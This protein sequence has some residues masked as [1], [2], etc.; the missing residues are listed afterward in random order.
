MAERK[1]A[2]SAR[3]AA[4][5]GYLS[6]LAAIDVRSLLWNL[7]FT[8]ALVVIVL[9]AAQHLWPFILQNERQPL[10]LLWMPVLTPTAILLL[11]TLLE[12]LLPPAGPRKSMEVWFL[13]LRIAIFQGFTF[14]LAGMAIQTLSEKYAKAHG[15][16]AGFV[17]LSFAT[18]KGILAMLAAAWLYL[19]VMD[20]FYYWFHRAFHTW[21]VLWAHHKLHHMDPELD[22]ITMGR[23]NWFEG[24]A[25]GFMMILPATL[26]FKFDNLDGWQMGVAAGI[27]ATFI[28]TV[29]MIGHLNVRIQAG[30][31]SLLWC[32]PQV[33]RIHHS[34]LP[35]HWDKN[36]AFVLPLWDYLFGTYYQPA[37]DEFPPTGVAGEVEI[38]SFW[39]SQIFTQ[40]EWWRLFV[41]FLEKRRARLPD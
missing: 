8:A 3:P 4:A 20:F 12:R 17:D 19:V 36:F 28:Q 34:T 30:R 31:F 29:V 10:A 38:R 22:A 1:L 13:H 23:D 24:I 25:A 27:M 5:P 16:S 18:G 41:S 32:T 14:D 35:H 15:F 26:I 2:Y 39:E 40:R 6:R 11:L 37:A 33:H 21:S 7:V 9:L